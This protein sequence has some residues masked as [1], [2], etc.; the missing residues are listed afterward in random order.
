MTCCDCE[1][2]N[3]CTTEIKMIRPIDHQLLNRQGY[4]NPLTFIVQKSAWLPHFIKPIN[5]LAHGKQMQPESERCVK[6]PKEALAASRTVDWVR[7]TGS[8]IY[9][10][11][12]RRLGEINTLLQS[13][14]CCRLI[15]SEA[16]RNVLNY[17]WLLMAHL[18]DWLSTHSIGYFVKRRGRGGKPHTYI[19]KGECKYCLS[20]LS[21]LHSSY[22]FINF[23][24]FKPDCLRCKHLWLEES[25][26]TDI[27]TK[28]DW[29]G[30]SEIHRHHIFGDKSWH[31]EL[32]MDLTQR[33]DL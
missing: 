5:T 33:K 31:Y 1:T 15:R 29:L 3:Q 6:E 18:S 25:C 17:L 7:D 30:A 8:V 26:F 19:Q 32:V 20:P 16:L 23:Q 2:I 11:R 28:P 12:G 24:I 27:Q 21:L 9:G 14:A 13:H 10:Q 4:Q 22:A